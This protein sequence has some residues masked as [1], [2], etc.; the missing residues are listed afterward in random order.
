MKPF[1]TSSVAKVFESY[2][3]KIR[4]KLLKLRELIFQ[5]GARLAEVGEIEETLKW[6]QPSYL[7]SETKSGTTIRIDAM[8]KE[9]GRYA[10][11]FHCQTSVIETVKNRFGD[12]FE[13]Q[14][15]R[16]LVFSEAEGLPEKELRECISLALTY[17]L[18][19][20]RSKKPIGQRINES[21]S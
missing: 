17:H 9:P 6:G 1:S 18:K 11:Y 13:Y 21:K 3:E 12:T 8:A 19:N 16:A 5:T 14:G 10:M 2:P 15:N 7:T 20:K 4:G